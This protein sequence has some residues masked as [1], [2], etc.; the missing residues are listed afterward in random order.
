M[1]S[2]TQA[3]STPRDSSVQSVDRAI[4][5]L[6]VLAREG[7]TG[8]TAIAAELGLHKSTVSR[9]L[10]TLEAR[11]LVEPVPGRG[12]YRLDYGVALLAQGVARKP[13]LTLV[14]RPVC[15]ELA[16]EIGET[17]NIDVR[18]G[19]SSV[20]ID[21]V[22]GPS[23]L[24]AVN[25]VGRRGPLHATSPGKVFLA[26][27]SRD[28]LDRYVGGGLAR[29]TDRTITDP[30]AL[31]RDLAAVRRRGYASTSEELEIGLVAV[32]VPIR[33]LDGATVATVS[34]SG[35][36]FRIGPDRIGELADR[37]TVAAAAISERNGY[38]KVG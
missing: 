10:G 37:L 2:T 23:S 25:W 12:G 33:D 3:G 35:P 20:T 17:V 9:L 38:P 7:V 30:T 4:S 31:A 29:F 1:T 21:Q 13:D 6:Q 15:S 14:S 24:T 26:D 8:V 34:T 5:I 28:A 11:G 27:F 19:D 22:T 32:A 16:E 36:V 18:Q